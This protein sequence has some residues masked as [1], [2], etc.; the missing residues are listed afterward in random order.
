[1]TVG[2]AQQGF[3]LLEIMVALAVA[4]VGLGAVSKAM[5]QNVDVVQQLEERTLAG[6]V[7]SN[8]MAELRL[9]RQFNSGGTSRSTEDMGGREWRIE[10]EFFSTNDPNISRVEVRVFANRSDDSA[11]ATEIGFLGRYK[12]AKTGS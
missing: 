1:M 10:E 9:L 2:S 6:W 3:T 11:S 5:I 7:A 8:R 12:P 4:A